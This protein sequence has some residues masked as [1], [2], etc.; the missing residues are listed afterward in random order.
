MAK[1]YKRGVGNLVLPYSPVCQN[2]SATTTATLAQMSRRRETWVFTINN[3][4]GAADAPELW[5]DVRIAFWQLERGQSGTPHYQ[6]YVQFNKRK[7]FTQVK[8]LSP[9]A[10]WERAVT[11]FHTNMQYCSKLEGRLLGPFYCGT[12]ESLKVTARAFIDE[13]SFPQWDD[14]LTFE[15]NM[16]ARKAHFLTVK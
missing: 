8:S 13:L 16:D 11:G 12:D 5:P 1:K 4:M 6:G 10:H 2:A 15:Q 3:P 7:S 9:R 14:N